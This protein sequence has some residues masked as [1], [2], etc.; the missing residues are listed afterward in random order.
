MKTAI[1][2]AHKSYD[3]R[4]HRHVRTLLSLGDEVDYYNISNG[5]A[6]DPGISDLH[7]NYIHVYLRKKFSLQTLKVAYRL[8]ETLRKTHYDYYFVQDEELLALFPLV[9]SIEKEK[10]IIDVHEML[11][12]DFLKRILIRALFSLPKKHRACLTALHSDVEYLKHYLNEVY[13][14]DN[15][16][17]YSDLEVCTEVKQKEKLN[18][19]YVGVITEEN[20]QML[21]TLDIMH[22][23]IDTGRFTATLIG[24]IANR[25][26]RDEIEYKIKHLQSEHPQDF[27]Y[28]GALGR[29]E[30]V[31]HLCHADI[32]IVLL[33]YPSDYKVAPNKFLE[34]IAAS[35]VLVTDHV[36]FPP[37]VPEHL[38]VKVDKN[39]TPDR[40]ADRIISLYDCQ[41][42]ILTLKKAIRE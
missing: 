4:I 34:A 15:L 27:H 42:K 35:L 6:P 40:I 25:T 41:E 29:K 37:A 33:S 7:F 24:P 16:P 31:A 5:S 9:R 12:T 13:G 30:V 10:I 18:V 39:D 14:L 11:H 8:I 32:M 20:K 38:I 1:L 19:I 22:K 17:L 3:Y 21:K 23:L 26:R 2:S 36:N 28:L